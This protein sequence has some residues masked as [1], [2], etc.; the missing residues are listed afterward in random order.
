MLY[1]NRHRNKK[2]KCGAEDAIKGENADTKE[3]TEETVE[4]S[5]VSSTVIGESEPPGDGGI[6]SWED[7]DV[8]ENMVNRTYNYYVT[9]L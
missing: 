6:E 9:I 7:L 3:E 4:L 5:A 8:E 1:G 2:E